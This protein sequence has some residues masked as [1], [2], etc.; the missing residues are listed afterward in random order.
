MK[1]LLWFF[2]LLDLFAC[3][4][5]QSPSHTEFPK[6]DTLIPRTQMIR[7][8]VDVHLTEA[9]LAYSKTSG[10]SK[11]KLIN[12]YYNAVFAKY[13]ISKKNFESNFDYY[14]NNQEDLIKMYEDVISTLEKLKKK[15]T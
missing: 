7:I 14:K 15:G 9:A 6:P 12:D 13:K 4:N 11:K 3:K 10:E 8:L 2:I 5:Q 1:H